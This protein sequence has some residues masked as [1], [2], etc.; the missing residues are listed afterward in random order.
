MFTK[1]MID[2]DSLFGEHFLVKNYMSESKRRKRRQSSTISLEQ[3]WAQLFQAF[4][5][6]SITIPNFQKLVAFVFCLPG[7]L[8]EFFQL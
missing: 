2:T 3:K 7:I 8:N 1:K 5:D 6:N 4:I